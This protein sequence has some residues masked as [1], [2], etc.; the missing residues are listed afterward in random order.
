MTIELHRTEQRRHLAIP[1]R[2][3]RL[4]ED[5]DVHDATACRIEKK[6]DRLNARA[7]GMLVSL[8]VASVMLALNLALRA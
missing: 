2:V 6:V 4:E 1:L 5:M 3:E 8:A 7:T